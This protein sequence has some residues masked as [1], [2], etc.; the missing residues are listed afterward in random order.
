MQVGM[1]GHILAEIHNRLF[2]GN[3]DPSRVVVLAMFHDASEVITGDLPTPIKYFSPEIKQA[4]KDIEE[5]ANERL[6]R[7][8]PEELK[9]AY[10]SI[11]FPNPE[12]SKAWELVKAADKISAYFKCLEEIKAGNQEFIKASEVLKSTIDEMKL[13]EITY[14]METFAPSMALTLDELDG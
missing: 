5:V 7:L 10:Q 12:E 2:E 13:P 1:I 6:F 9:G 4:Y 3:V 8:L 11:L 14:F